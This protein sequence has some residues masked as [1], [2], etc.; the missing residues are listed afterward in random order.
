MT[1][2]S[3]PQPTDAVRSSAD[4]LDAGRA[5][6][7]RVE[8]LLAELTVPEKAGQLH[9]GFELDPVK[10]HDEIAAG[11]VGA[12][13]YSYGANAVPGAACVGLASTIAG[14]QQVA[15]AESRLGIPLLF[16]SDVVHGMRTTFPIPLGL[17]ATWDLDLVKACATQAAREA[18]AEGLHLTFAPM[19]D[20][21][22]EHRWGRIG[23][24]FGDEPLLAGRVGAA[25]VTGF[26]ADGRFSATAKHFCGYG[27]VQAERDHETLSVG[28]NAMHNLH[29]RP[30]R[31][32]VAAGSHAIMV[33]FHDV[34]GV[35][36]HTHQGLVRD[37][38]KTE[39]GFTGVV[40]SDWDG[41]GQL[42]HQGVATDR[43][44]AARQALLAGV[45]LD[46]VSGA[47]RDYLPDLVASGEVGLDLLDDA[48]RRVLR[49]KLR[50]GLFDRPAGRPASGSRSRHAESATTLA[51]R[52]AA[53]SM[54]LLKNS[55]I[56]PLHPNVGTVHLCGPFVDDVSALLG[57]WVFPIENPGTDSAVTPAAAFAERLE[58]G[59]LV[60]SDGRFSDLA[61]RHADAADLTIAIVGE[62]P[63]RGGE[64]RSLPTADLPVGQLELLGALSTVGKPLVVVVVTGRPLELRPVLQLA[65]AVLVAWHPGMA[66]GTALA[67]VLLGTRAPAG[68]LPMNL[69]QLAAQGAV[70][71]IDPTSGRRLGRSRDARFSRYLTAL[72]HPELSLG[73]GLS[74]TTFAYSEIELSRDRLPLRGGVIRASVEVANTGRR[75][76]R[77]VVQ[78]YIRDLVADVVRPMVEL[79]DWRL[80][81][82]E[83]GR[84]T[85]VVFRITADM[86]AYWGRDL[87]H[88][89]EPGEVDVIIGPNAARGSAARVTITGEVTPS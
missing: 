85:K 37:L 13:I 72:E 39:W 70:G 73:Y 25:T 63:S 8:L 29:L 61:V 19:V 35:P 71:I 42:V 66:S 31:A 53:S 16:G 84:S 48:V 17:A 38:L 87:V 4:W 56:L 23:E 20:I 24:T 22:S 18:A 1:T 78:L 64:D 34:D 45:D 44:D 47:Y 65:D 83:P 68:R 59:N 49:L 41:I 11:R 3:R 9:L 30:F 82:L 74:Y 2:T 43:R 55:G 89:V 88:R 62:H 50:A 6:D 12:G 51:T 58:A 21:S 80:V 46:M 14:C 75:A 67:D 52:A 79:A 57:T 10:H 76:G 32:A 26:Q 54:V 86:F 36:M 77:E 5:L 69:P 81:D 60:V 40:V 7:E 28:L 27:V 33:G 15:R